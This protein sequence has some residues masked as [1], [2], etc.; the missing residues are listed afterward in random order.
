MPGLDLHGIKSYCAH[1]HWGSI[2]ALGT[3]PGGFRADIAGGVEPTRRVGLLDLLIDPYF[4]GNLANA[5]ITTRTLAEALQVKDLFTLSSTDLAQLW[6]KIVELLRGQLLSGT[7]M[8]LRLGIREL[9]SIDILRPSGQDIAELDMR[10]GQNYTDIFSWYRRTMKKCS[11]SALI[12]PVHPEFYLKA[13][14]TTAEIE[15]AALMRTVLRIDPLL[16]FWKPESPRRE[17]LASS[18]GIDPADAP[19][20]R[21]F[22]NALFDLAGQRGAVGIKQLQAYS[23]PLAFSYRQDHEVRFRGNLTP[24]EVRVF[25]DWV[26]H[27]C[28]SQAHERSWP[29]QVHVGT[30]N[31]G[32]SA[33]L[34]LLDLARRYPRMNIVQLHCWPFLT[35]AGWLSKQVPNI[36]IDTCWLPILNPEYYRQA[37]AGWINYVP[38]HKLCCSHDATSIEMAAGSLAI[39]QGIAGRVLAEQRSTMTTSDEQLFTAASAFFYDNAVSLYGQPNTKE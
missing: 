39:A 9:Y 2:A 18:L 13:V 26:V 11:F 28:S 15:E 34:P 23:R 17:A 38:S 6:P 22:I 14:A 1:E 10:V 30:H 33:P 7:F 20:W 16:D 32:E 24:G 8:S 31:L 12:R 3:F 29:Q 27:A 25:Q 35:E 21:M 19:S 36:Y 37:L 4:G 5:G